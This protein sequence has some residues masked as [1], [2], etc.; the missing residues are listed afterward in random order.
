MTEL[1]FIDYQDL[2]LSEIDHQ[3]QRLAYRHGLPAHELDD[4]R[5]DLVADLLSRAHAYDDERASP[6]TFVT[7]VTTNRAALL[8]GGT[9]ASVVYLGARRSP[10]TSRSATTRV[11]R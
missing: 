6:S 2:I 10:S 4:L 8:G 3:A 11:N 9:S 7:M 5:Q 1:R